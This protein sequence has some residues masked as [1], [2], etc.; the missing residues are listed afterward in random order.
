MNGENYYNMYYGV[1][2]FGLKVNRKAHVSKFSKRSHNHLVDK[3]FNLKH[4]VRSLVSL[5]G[6][7]YHKPITLK[8]VTCKI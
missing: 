2:W 7:K 1:L 3:I 6:V 4:M 8:N 5:H